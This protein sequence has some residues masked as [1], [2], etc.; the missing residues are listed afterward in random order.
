MFLCFDLLIGQK[1]KKNI[2]NLNFMYLSRLRQYQRV[3]LFHESSVIMVQ[4]GHFSLSFASHGTPSPN[5]IRV[6]KWINCF[7]QI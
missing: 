5:T 3:Y 6:K 7:K 1:Q 2:F 4:H